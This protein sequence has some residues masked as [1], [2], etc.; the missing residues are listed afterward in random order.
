MLPD[1]DRADAIGSYWGNPKT[2]AFGELLID[3]E[4]DRTLGAVLVG[5]LREADPELRRTRAGGSRVAR[6]A[7]FA[8]P[9]RQLDPDHGPL[10]GSRPFTLQSHEPRKRATANAP[11]TFTSLV[12]PAATMRPLDPISTANGVL[13]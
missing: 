1:F 6:L 12:V 13:R 9:A 8:L 10:S 4:E 11:S 2:H 7:E 5:M 3:C